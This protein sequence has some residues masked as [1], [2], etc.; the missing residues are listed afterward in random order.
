MA[1][2][3]PHQKPNPKARPG[4]KKGQKKFFLTSHLNICYYH[5]DLHYRRLHPGSRPRLHHSFVF[6]QKNTKHLH[7]L[8]L[9]SA[10]HLRS[11]LSI[12]R[13]LKRHPFSGL[14]HS[15]R[16]LRF[17][18]AMDRSLGFAASPVLLTKNGPLRA[19]P[20]HADRFT[21]VTPASCL[22]KV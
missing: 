10:S 18:Q 6:C 22:F 15:A 1:N 4:R 19:V 17:T 2:L 16:E 9:T 3:N 12:G 20:H 11:W 13:P 7:V 21:Q 14:V 8:L 5:Q